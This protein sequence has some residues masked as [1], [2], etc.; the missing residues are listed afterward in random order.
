MLGKIVEQRTLQEHNKFLLEQSANS[1]EKNV[2][3][4]NSERLSRTVKESHLPRWVWRSTCL[5]AWGC[6]WCAQRCTGRCLELWPRRSR[7][8]SQ[9]LERC[10]PRST[11]SWLSPEER[12]QWRMIQWGQ[13]CTIINTNLYAF[14]LFFIVLD[15][16]YDR[17]SV[18]RER[19]QCQ[20]PTLF[21]TGRQGAW[22]S[23]YF[24]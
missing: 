17:L 19:Y 14:G 7:S 2:K 13:R 10:E 1:P 11:N 5:P 6:R 15:D 3:L 22:T 8:R 21:Y 4:R 23:C 12:I 20:P 9:T 24:D 18:G 16:S